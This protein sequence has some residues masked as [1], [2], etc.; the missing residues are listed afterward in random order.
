MADETGASERIVDLDA[1]GDALPDLI[2][3]AARRGERLV[4]ER[5][6]VMLAVLVP[7]TE[8]ARNQSTDAVRDRLAIASFRSGFADLTDDEI[9]REVSRAIANSRMGDETTVDVRR[10]S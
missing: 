8:T 4:V 7:A 1:A 9:Q 6:G 2:E 10:A 3:D 5:G